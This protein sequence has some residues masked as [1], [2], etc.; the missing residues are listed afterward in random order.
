MSHAKHSLIFSGET[1]W[2]YGE[3]I[4]ANNHTRPMLKPPI[5]KKNTIGRY[6]LK[7]ANH[8][9]I[10]NNL[11]LIYQPGKLESTHQPFCQPER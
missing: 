6:S 1:L 5:A 7:M 9:L 3:K 11:S 8:D 10:A 2:K 4:L